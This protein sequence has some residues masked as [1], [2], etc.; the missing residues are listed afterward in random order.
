MKKLILL[1]LL[2]IA[3]M[4]SDACTSAIFTG[5]VTQSGRPIMWKNRDTGELNNRVDK[6]L[7]NPAKGI[8]YTFIALVNSTQA[9]EREAWSGTNEK[10]FSI[11]NT[12]SYNLQDPNDKT[13]ENTMDGEGSV[14]F[15]A[16]A[17]CATLKDFEKMLDKMQKPFHVETNFGVIDAE[18][19]AAY[20]EVN[21]YGWTKLDANDPKIA[22]QGY[23]VYTNHSFTGRLDEGMGYIRYNNAKDNISSFLGRGGKITPKWVMNNLSRSYY[24]SLL[25]IDL[26]KNPELAPNG[27]YIDQDFIPRRSTSAVTIVEGIYP[28]DK[29]EDI[30]TWVEIGSPPISMINPVKVGEEI[31]EGLRRISEDDMTCTLC[32][33]SLEIK[34]QIFPISRGNGKYY[35]NLKKTLEVMREIR[36]LEEKIW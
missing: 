35:F 31:P 32:N 9:A 28:G 25:G 5:K 19:G 2:L 27:W 4:A 11:M 15:K 23:I 21:N 18:G 34:K 3:P 14:M 13:P 10:G 12:A 22:P 26:A 33:Q 1:A 6:I 17:T 8:K 30:T 20:Y 16:L 24:H 36:I 29:L 7:A